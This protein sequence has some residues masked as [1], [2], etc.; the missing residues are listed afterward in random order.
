MAAVLARRPRQRGFTM[1]ELMMVIAIIGVLA[2]IAIPSYQVY[3]AKA[4][5]GSAFHEAVSIKTGLETVLY[6][7]IVPTLENVGLASTTENCSSVLTGSSDGEN[8]LVCT[9]IGGPTTVR[10]ETITITRGVTSS[11]VTSWT[12]QTTV[13]RRFVGGDAMCIGV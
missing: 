6:D 1:I 13:A 4:K 11:G 8:V 7:G 5:F 12:C 10:G 3:V 9:I 2:A